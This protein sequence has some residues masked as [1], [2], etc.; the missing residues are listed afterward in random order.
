MT[1]QLHRKSKASGIEE[2]DNNW[3]IYIGTKRDLSHSES[4]PFRGNVYTR[5]FAAELVLPF[6]P[7]AEAGPGT[8][9]SFVPATS[10][11]IGTVCPRV[12]LYVQT[13]APMSKTS[14]QN[15]HRPFPFTP[16]AEAGPGI[17]ASFV[18]ATRRIIGTIGTRVLFHKKRHPI[19]VPGA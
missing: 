5:R 13:T 17:K 9:T 19:A 18:P 2:V 14:P 16:C 15:R 4:G 3:S 8:K 6:V 10:R 12:L 1:I 11:I 7:Y